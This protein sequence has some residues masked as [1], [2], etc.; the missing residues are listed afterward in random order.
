MPPAR[1]NNCLELGELR[2]TQFAV[3]EYSKEEIERKLTTVRLDHP[4]SDK[5]NCSPLI[6]WSEIAFILLV[7]P[8]SALS[9]LHHV[10]KSMDAHLIAALNMAAR[11]R[12]TA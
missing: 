3:F 7:I 1:Q 6:L 11:T 4:R 8:A 5:T 2:F 9:S 12:F 10:S